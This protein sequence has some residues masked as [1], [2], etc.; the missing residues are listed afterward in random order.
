VVYGAGSTPKFG[1][2][3]EM[4]V[5]AYRV[6]SLMIIL[7]AAVASAQTPA[8]PQPAPPAA[9]LQQVVT[10]KT[11]YDSTKAQLMVTK[12]DNL[13]LKANAVTNDFQAQMKS[14]Q[15]EWKAQEDL[16]TAWVESVR[17][18]N[19]WDKTYTYDRAKDQWTHTPAAPA[20]KQKPAPAVAPKK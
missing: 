11:P 1:I 17:K 6:L 19:G 20:P 12:E 5:K 14:F 9:P 8:P 18:D 15:V 3:K 2:N 16:I 13:Q 7:I 4:E 10:P